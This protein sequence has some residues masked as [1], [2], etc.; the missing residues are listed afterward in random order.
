MLVRC[1]VEEVVCLLLY[2]GASLSREMHGS[3]LDLLETMVV[4]AQKEKKS[5][6]PKDDYGKSWR[7][8]ESFGRSRFIERWCK[9]LVQKSFYEGCQ[10]SNISPVIN[11]QLCAW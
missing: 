7:K 10:R 9:I 6:E 5:R 11:N 3:N 1:C 4:V 8:P 2:W